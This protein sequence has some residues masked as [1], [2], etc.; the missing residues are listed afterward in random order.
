ME[1]TPKPIIAALSHGVEDG[2]GLHNIAAKMQSASPEYNGM[3][4][5][6]MGVPDF[7]KML[8]EQ[9]KAFIKLCSV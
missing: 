5:T 3:P 1:K 4:V 8:D 2:G 9:K 6:E 7:S